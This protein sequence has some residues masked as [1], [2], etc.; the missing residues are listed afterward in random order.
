MRTVVVEDAETA[1]TVSKHHEIL[2][3]QT[4]AERCAAGFSH[5]LGQAGRHPMAPHDL[6]HGGIAFDAAEQFV[7]FA[8]K[9]Q[10]RPGLEKYLVI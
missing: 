2:A 5:V 10:G 3:E 9:H 4:D 7:F 1:F 8:G 6:T